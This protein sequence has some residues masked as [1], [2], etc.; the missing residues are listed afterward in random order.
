MNIAAPARKADEQQDGDLIV[1]LIVRGQ[2]IETD[3]VRHRMRD[4]GRQFLA[5]ALDRH[6]DKLP[7]GAAALRDLYAI[8][9]D[10][11]IDFLADVGA[12]LSLDYNP[13]LRLAFEMSLRASELPESILESAYENLPKAF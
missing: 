8:G 6:L 3:L 10:E 11:I 4:G 9:I 5:P 13:H 7:I 12:S 1:P 2:V